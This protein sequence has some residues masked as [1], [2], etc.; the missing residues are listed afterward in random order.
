MT[1]EPTM[2]TAEEAAQRVYAKRLADDG[3]SKIRKRAEESQEQH[4]NRLAAKERKTARLDEN[5]SRQR[6]SKHIFWLLTK[7][8]S[9]QASY[10]TLTWTR[11]LRIW[12]RASKPMC[13]SVTTYMDCIIE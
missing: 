2:A 9:Y 1:E 5:S 8:T 6:E 7:M 3:E 4:E 12:K 10:T 11:I 13:Y